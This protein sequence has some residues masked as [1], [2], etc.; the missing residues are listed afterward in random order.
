MFIDKA[1]M[2]IGILCL[3][4]WAI[5]NLI[6]AFNYS[7]KTMVECFWKEQT[8]MGKICANIFYAPAWVLLGVAT[9]VLVVLVWVLVPIYK[10]LKWLV[11]EFLHPLYRK[12]IRFEL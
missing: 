1:T 12:A 7:F 9:A 4:A 11:V 5:A 8:I 2:I 3:V 10:A 6:V